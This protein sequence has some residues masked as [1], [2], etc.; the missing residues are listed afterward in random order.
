MQAPGQAPGM[1][2]GTPLVAGQAATAT[3]RGA[4]VMWPHRLVPGRD[5]VPFWTVASDVSY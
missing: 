4:G 3:M 5:D 2:L 1:R